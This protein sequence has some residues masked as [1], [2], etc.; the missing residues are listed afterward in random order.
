MTRCDLI[1]A[2][3]LLPTFIIMSAWQEPCCPLGYS[4]ATGNPL[5][6]G[7]IHDTIYQT[8]GLIESSQQIQTA[9]VVYNAGVGVELLGNAPAIESVTGRGRNIWDLQVY[10]DQ[11]F[12][13]YG[14]TTQNT[15]PTALYAYHTIEDT[16]GKVCTLG[17]EAIERFRV[18]NDTLFVPN[19][20]PKP[21]DLLKFSYVVDGICTDV[22]SSHLL[23]HVRDMYFHQGKYYLVGNS[24]CPRQYDPAC[25]GL[26]TL[27]GPSWTHE[28]S[29]L[30]DLLNQA[31]PYTNNRWNW[32]FGILAIDSA[33]V[34]PNA[35]FTERYNPNLVIEDNLFYHL[36]G[37]SLL[38]SALEVPEQ[39]LKHQ[40]FYPAKP[41]VAGTGDTL[42]LLTSLRVTEHLTLADKTLY[43]LRSYSIFS[44]LYQSAYNNSKGLLIKDS[45]RSDALLVTLPDT[46]AI[47][48][49]L[50]L[51]NGEAYVLANRKLTPDQFEVYVYKSEDPS[52]NS[53]SWTEVLRFTYTNMARSFAFHQGF[54]YFGMG[55]NHGDDLLDAG[56]L[57]KVDTR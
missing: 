29:H 13:G 42:G 14:S 19:A 45:L 40:H 26:I 3:L 52:A 38:W 47:G 35:M 2:L 57:I 32:F 49:D 7:V 55:S 56:Q 33:L 22:S 12:L 36:E 30:T 39:R 37:D 20:D 11:I 1:W 21:G 15:G 18:F 28:N 4:H 25:S 6:I 8:Q 17:T 34:F 16:L 50:L 48:E 24:R 53:G 44:E 31:S 27:T 10:K 51:L 43:T 23:A 54:F 9:E 5:E 46:Q 41:A